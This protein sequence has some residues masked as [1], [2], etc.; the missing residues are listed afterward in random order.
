MI[1]RSMAAD[2]RA[3]VPEAPVIRTLKQLMQH[4]AARGTNAETLRASATASVD[5]PLRVPAA[6]LDRVEHWTPDDPVLR[7]VLP[8][9]QECKPADGYGNDPVGELERL[10]GA[11]LRKYS[12]RALLITTQACDVHCRYCF[13]RNFDYT[14]AQEPGNYDA[15]F[16]HIADDSSIDELILSGGDPLTLSDRRMAAVIDAAERIPHLNTLRLHTRSAIVNPGRVTARLTGMLA[17]TRLN[18]VCVVH[19]NTALEI[20]PDAE[21]AVRALR[22]VGATLLNQAVLL[23]GVNDSVDA[24]VA[25][26]KRLHSC[27]VLPY[28]LHQLDPVAGAAHFQVSDAR[29]RSMLNAMRGLLPGYLVPKLVREVAGEPSKTPL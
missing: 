5:F 21:M 17:A 26:S 12:G 18:V 25:L 16:A 9:E 29:A 1:Q 28:Y 7:Q 20:G 2:A 27:G 10:D 3:G 15:A 19:A 23:A 22:N 14:A 6:L 11:L 8:S 24:L 13:R 4:A